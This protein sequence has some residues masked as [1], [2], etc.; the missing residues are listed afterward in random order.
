MTYN[1]NGNQEDEFDRA[2]KDSAAG[3]WGKAS[4]DAWECALVK[5]VGKEPWDP[6]KHAGQ[7]SHVCISFT[8]EPLDPARKLISRDMINWTT[9]FRVAVR[10]SIEELAEPLAKIVG[11]EVGSFNPLRELNGKWVHGEFVPRPDNK[12]DETW[13][14]IRFTEVF[15]DRGEC[16]QAALEAGAI[17]PVQDG[18]GGG[19][20]A[21]RASLAQFLPALWNEAQGAPNP[22][23]EMEGK[24]KANPLLAQFFNLSSPEVQATRAEIQPQSL[25][26]RAIGLYRS[27]CPRT[28]EPLL[29]QTLIAMP[30]P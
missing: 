30:T 11:K 20:D 28:G 14:T 23:A 9:E 2:M 22:M 21:Q 17:Q 12:P 26:P 15:R 6:D 3:F 13:T 7:N 1:P 5:G 4:V 10:P 19:N 25:L 29:L 18:L 16:S 24:I 8:I 27:V